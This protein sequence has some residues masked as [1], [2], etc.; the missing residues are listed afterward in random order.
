MPS[1]A[2]EEEQVVVMLYLMSCSNERRRSENCLSIFL[3]AKASRALVADCRAVSRMREVWASITSLADKS[4]SEMLSSLTLREDKLLCPAV[5]S[6][7][8]IACWLVASM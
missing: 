3:S 4:D 8:F 2:E 1:D 5:V 6:L 7:V